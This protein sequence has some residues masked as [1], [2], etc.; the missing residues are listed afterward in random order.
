[1]PGDQGAVFVDVTGEPLDINQYV[2]L[3]ADPGAGAISTFSGV[4]RNN[5]QGKAVVKL[6]Y[7]AYTPMALKKLREL[8]QDVRQRWDVCSVAIGHRIGTVLVGEPSVI[9]AVSSA[10]RRES[11]EGITEVKSEVLRLALADVK[12]DI[13]ELS[14][15]VDRLEKEVT[16]IAT[17]QAE[18]AARLH[19]LE[20]KVDN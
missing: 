14:R 16:T 4:T 9:I 15:K 19:R 17:D 13:T 10:H 12:S 3:V 7:E 20:E 18:M 5:F 8:A 6:D 2:G 1:M 11:L